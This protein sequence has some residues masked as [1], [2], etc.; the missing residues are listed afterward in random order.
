MF[1][2]QTIAARS[3]PYRLV[4]VLDH[5]LAV[6]VGDVEVDVRVLFP[7]HRGEPLEEEAVFERV[8]RAE[9]QAVEQHRGRR[10]AS[11]ADEDAL[12]VAEIDDVFEDEQVA[13]QLEALTISKLVDDPA[14]ERLGDPPLVVASWRPP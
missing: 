8:D 1:T 4:D 9:A 2:S 7:L 11:H 5:A 3:R 10:R 12:A 13:R 14:T 6:L